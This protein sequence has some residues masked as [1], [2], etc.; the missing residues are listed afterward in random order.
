MTLTLESF[1]EFYGLHPWTFWQFTPPASHAGACNP[2]IFEEGWQNADAVSRVEII[3]AIERSEVLF[4]QN[5]HYWPYRRQV[6]DVLAWPGWPGRRTD[7]RGRMIE[8]AVADVP[9]LQLGVEVFELVGVVPVATV[10]PDSDGYPNYFEATLSTAHPAGE[11]ELY[12][13]DSDR[14]TAPIG[15]RWQVKASATQL[16]GNVRFRGGPWQLVRPDLVQQ[17]LPNG[18]DPADDCSYVKTLEVWRRR[19]VADGTTVDTA[20]VVYEYQSHPCSCGCVNVADP[21]SVAQSLG[22]GLVQSQEYGRIALAEATWDGT[23]WAPVCC[24]CSVPDRVRVRYVSGPLDQPGVDTVVLKMTASEL[25]RPLCMCGQD[26]VG[27]AMLAYYQD[28]M[29]LV[30]P[31]RARFNIDQVLL[32][33]PI[34]TRRGHVDAW[35]WIQSHAVTRAVA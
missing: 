4:Q 22:R 6:E 8:V 33:N 32:S 11:L 34:G 21:A 9:A 25:S 29:A 3:N 2:V 19:F 14:L 18:I 16:T 23:G 12:I 17:A 10:D 13:T 31:Q 30:L 35:K 7:T 26:R 27:S 24:G 15:R 28:D 5:A 1:R 20:S